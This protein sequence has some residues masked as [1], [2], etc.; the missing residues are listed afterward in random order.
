MDAL[1]QASATSQAAAIR[2]GEVSS[3]ELVRAHLDR[4]AAVNPAL[5]AVIQSD[6]DAALAAARSADARLAAGDAAGPFDGVPFTAK[7]WLETSDLICTAGFASRSNFRP[8]RDATVVARMRAA[9]AILLGKTNTGETNEVYGTTR[10]PRDTLRSPGASSSGEA[11][12][13]AAGGSPLG[14]GSDSG[15]SLRYPA[16][17]CGVA[18]LKPTTGRVPLTG[19][20]PRINP[21][22]DPRT[23]IGPLS[24]HVEDLWP[25]LA[26]I[27]GVDWRDPSVMP[28]SLGTLPTGVS[29]M[30][31][32]WY[33]EMPGANPTRETRAAVATAVAALSAAGANVEQVEVPRLAESM[34]LTRTYW[35]RVQSPGWNEWT[36][37]KPHTLTNEEIERSIFEWDRFRR[38]LL[39]FMEPFDLLVCPAAEGPAPVHGTVGAQEYVYTLPH[40]LTGWPVATLP[41]GASPENLPLGVQLVAK[42]WHE[43]TA[44]AAALVVEAWSREDH[45][46]E[47][48]T[49]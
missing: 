36:P 5:N 7:D 17:C 13:I 22:H 45:R 31:I 32:G 34:P 19:H 11:A 25:A 28:V 44:A 21:S 26:V 4:I 47:A 12:I 43:A 40:S 9:G 18:T 41:A 37:D 2:A 14:L 1:L 15:G 8:R 35:R 30:R 42:P 3:E 48:R 24:R 27:S 39:A 23:V 10:N 46:P 20:F 6:P 29:G 49:N 38:T 16:H 33:T